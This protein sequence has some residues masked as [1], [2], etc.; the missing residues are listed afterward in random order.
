MAKKINT[1][2]SILFFLLFSEN[3]IRTKQEKE[4]TNTNHLY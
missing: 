1:I 4:S 3:R 2:T